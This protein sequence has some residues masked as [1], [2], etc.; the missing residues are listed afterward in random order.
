MSRQP[1]LYTLALTGREVWALSQS[2]DASFTD[3]EGR[4]ETEIAVSRKL[5]ALVQRAHRDGALRRK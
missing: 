3:P 4:D 2:Y 1:K 5:D